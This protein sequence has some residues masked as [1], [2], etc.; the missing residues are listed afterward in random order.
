VLSA[1]G[2]G[3]N[4]QNNGWGGACLCAGQ[5]LVIASKTLRGQI[6]LLF[7]DGDLLGGA[8]YL[9]ADAFGNLLNFP[10]GFQEGLDLCID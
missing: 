7:A 5:R 10:A 8:V 2:L 1:R 3:A 4:G 6:A 9:A